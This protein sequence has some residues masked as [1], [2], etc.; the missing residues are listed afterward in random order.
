VEANLS[1]TMT[2][3]RESELRP[4]FTVSIKLPLF[5]AHCPSFLLNY[6]FNIHHLS[7]TVAKENASSPVEARLPSPSSPH[8]AIGGGTIITDP[9]EE[10]WRT[11]A[12]TESLKGGC[13]LAILVLQNLWRF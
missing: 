13:I 7:L 11:T 3:F 10:T 9:I 12:K 2:W 6:L 4:S 8:S 1:D 5:F